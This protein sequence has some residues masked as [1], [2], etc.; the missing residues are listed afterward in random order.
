M[1]I[2]ILVGVVEMILK[3]IGEKTGEIGDQKKNRDLSGR[4]IVKI[5]LNTDKSPEDLRGL[6]VTQTPVKDYHL[7]LL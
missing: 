2:P 6:A 1:R 5:G 7:T 4:S 3:K